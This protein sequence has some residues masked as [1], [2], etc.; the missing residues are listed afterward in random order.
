MIVFELVCP[1]Q[2]RFEG[3]FSSS[4]DF[5]SQRSHGLLACPVCGNAEVEKLLT[6]KIGKGTGLV[7]RDLK[8]RELSKQM[9]A[10][11]SSVSLQ[12]FIDHVLLNT[13][14]VGDG[15]AQEA[16]RIHHREARNRNIRGVATK[17]ETEK[18]QEEGIPVLPLPIPNRGDWH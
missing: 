16:R 11:A 17:E 1:E 12:E 18:L 2:H 13:E 6:S 3:W 10:Q 15:F 5:N 4:E 14:D 9:P 7:E 8:E